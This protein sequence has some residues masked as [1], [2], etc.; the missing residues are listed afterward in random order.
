MALATKSLIEA[1]RL[2]AMLMRWESQLTVVLALRRPQMTTKIA[3]DAFLVLRVRG[4]S[5]LPRAGPGGWQLIRPVLGEKTAG[6]T[7]LWRLRPP[8]AGSHK[9]DTGDS[10]E[11]QQA[12]TTETTGETAGLHASDAT[13]DASN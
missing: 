9:P 7:E 10:P 12:A 6:S 4:L 3:A 5:L 8:A 1:R 13:A 2:R 11:L